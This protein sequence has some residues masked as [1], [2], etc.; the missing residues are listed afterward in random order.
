MNIT[1]VLNT[2]S[3]IRTGTG[4][5]DINMKQCYQLVSSVMYL[6]VSDNVQYLEKKQLK[7]VKQITKM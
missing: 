3:L 6:Y 7:F 2:Y 4:G 1:I 5:K